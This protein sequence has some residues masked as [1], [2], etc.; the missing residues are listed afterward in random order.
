MATP[1]IGRLREAFPDARIELLTTDWAEPAVRGCTLVDEVICVPAGLFFSKSASSLAGLVRLLMQLRSRNYD[2]AVVFHVS[3]MIHR[4]VAFTG[5]PNRFGFG[6]VASARLVLLEE[7]RHSALVNCDL[8][9]LVI[10]SSGGKQLAEVSMTDL[11]YHWKISPD[12]DES[13]SRYLNEAAIVHPFAVL[14][15]G[16]GSNPSVTNTERRWPADKYAELAIWLREERKLHVLILGGASDTA[17]AEQVVE[18]VGNDV[19]SLAGLTDLRTT[20]AIVARAEVSISNDSAPM[21]I[22]SA[23]GTPTVGV[24]GPTGAR[25][26]APLGERCASVSLGLP[27]SPCYFTKFQGCIYDNIRC[28]NELSASRV[29]ESVTRILAGAEQTSHE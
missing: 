12:E 5:I 7:M 18:L 19:I 4:W 24:F 16:G 3:R 6:K 10:N 26:K 1:A 9:D 28:M 11:K 13:A 14:F 15:P 2:I 29:A 20:A 27:C 8:A 17:V 23:V 22:S 25:T 21:H